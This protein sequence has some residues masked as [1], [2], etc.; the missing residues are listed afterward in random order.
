[1]WPNYFITATSR[2]A[3][4]PIPSHNN[5]LTRAQATAGETEKA[6]CLWTH[7]ISGDC[8]VIVR[9]RCANVPKHAKKMV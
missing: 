6:E 5:H 8:E 9:K 1:M 2:Q 4:F 7:Q 3:N